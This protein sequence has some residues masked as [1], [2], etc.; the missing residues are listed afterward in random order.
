MKHYKKSSNKDQLLEGYYV[1]LTWGIYLDG[2]E[3][4][5]DLNHAHR[6]WTKYKD[7][8]MADYLPGGQEYSVKCPGSLPWAYWKFEFGIERPSSYYDQMRKLAKMGKLKPADLYLIQCDTELAAMIAKND[9]ALRKLFTLKNV[10][11]L[12]MKRKDKS[13]EAEEAEE[14]WE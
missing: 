14:L 10:V 5:D 9:K 8:I 6:I 11:N 7:K 2:D 13:A 3:E 4:F 1:F 12:E